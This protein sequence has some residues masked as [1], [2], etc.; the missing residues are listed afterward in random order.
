MPDG[1]PRRSRQD[2]G[3][4]RGTTRA[5][6]A[7]AALPAPPLSPGRRAARAPSL[8]VVEPGEELPAHLTSFIGRT[9]E[10]ADVRRLLGEARLVTLTGVGG[11]GKTRIALRVVA[12]SR[13]RY[14]GGR[15][16][17]DLSAL[18][19][20]ALIAR[21]I[22]ARLGLREQIGSTLE[23]TLLGYLKTRS[24]LRLV[25]RLLLACPGL[26]ILATSREPF[27]IPGERVAQVP[28][29]ALP[30]SGVLTHPVGGDGVAE[31][32]RQS[33]AVALFVDRATAATPAFR[34][35]DANAPAI[36]RICQYL[37]G[38]PLAIELA[39]A[40]TRTFSVEQLAARLGE[41]FWLVTGSSRTSQPRHRTLEASVDWSYELLVG[42]EQTLLRALSVFAGGFTDEAAERVGSPRQADCDDVL[43]LLSQLVSKS[44]VILEQQG[45]RTRYRLL[46]TIR[47]YGLKKLREAGEEDLIRR[48]H[49]MFYATLAHRAE[50][51]L[52]GATQLTWFDRF[53]VEHDN[54]R[55]ALDWIRS[56]VERSDVEAGRAGLEAGAALGWFW[57]A[58]GYYSEGRN[59]LPKLLALTGQSVRTPARV[60]ALHH[61]SAC[62]Y[63]LGDHALIRPLLDEA[64]SLGR[65]LGYARG[66]AMAL[67]G[68]GMMAQEEGD[69][70]RAVR[71][72]DEGLAVARSA[73]DTVATYLLLI[74]RADFD[75]AHGLVD[76]AAELL[77]ESLQLSRA[78]GDGWWVGHAL[79]RL[80]HL[81]LLRRDYA[82]ATALGQEGLSRRW[83]LHDRQGAAWNLELLAWVAGAWGRPERAARLLAA[84]RAARERTGARLLPQEQ[85]GHDRT[86]ATAR[87]ALGEQAFAAAWAEGQARPPD[88]AVEYALAADEPATVGAAASTIVRNGPATARASGALTSREVEVVV[89]IA[90]GYTNRQIANDL[91]IARGTVA[92]HVAHILDKLGFHSRAQVAGWAA[93]QQLHGRATD[94]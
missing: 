77:E 8:A 92:N 86:L 10:I 82:R 59:R 22:A 6:T 28:P 31:R 81:A 13:R 55:A 39:A 30:D 38:L 91:V 50:P 4:G 71:L 87:A 73:R 9:R 46:E 94:S 33:E 19:D 40:R 83:E 47:Q 2:Q 37:D 11:V 35:T 24:A 93:E 61:A 18:A 26:R 72:Y 58:R 3:T 16:L 53:E 32:L 60:D 36:A 14:S 56:A 5:A 17:V 48:R 75:R 23:D 43:D 57:I 52:F 34:L 21:T 42:P 51:E 20:G 29:L 67:K 64:V 88:P 41:R 76:H 63:I 7:L 65:Q 68:L 44:L 62:C 54:V 80:A 84:A 70:R 12:G 27:E 66:T 25:E 78:Q 85:D 1:R 90:R 74:W 49:A 15:W 89:L 45:A 69:P 79:A